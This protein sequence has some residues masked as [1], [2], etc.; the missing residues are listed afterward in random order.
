LGFNSALLLAGA[1]ITEKIFNR[2]GLGT[3]Q[4]MR[5]SIKRDLSIGTGFGILMISLDLHFCEYFNGYCYRFLYP[6]IKGQLMERQR[7][8]THGYEG[9]QKRKSILSFVSLSVLG[10]WFF[11]ISLCEDLMIRTNHNCPLL[12]IAFRLRYFSKRAKPKSQSLNASPSKTVGK[13]SAWQMTR[14]GEMF[15]RVLITGR[16][17]LTELR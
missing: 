14:T 7:L 17:F 15:L 16:E 13:K 5:G 3:L 10:G 11:S 6:R 12:L 2:P 1:V 8:A 9:T 4:W